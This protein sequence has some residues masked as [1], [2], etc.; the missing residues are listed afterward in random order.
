MNRL[1]AIAAAFALI[2][3]PAVA[4]A[5]DFV[6]KVKTSDLNLQ[7]EGGARTALNRIHSAAKDACT[8]KVVGSR[9]GRTDQSC[10]DQVSA[11]LVKRLGAPLV[12]AAFEARQT[13]G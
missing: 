1:T 12:Q 9:I 8:D 13:K 6:A 11:E 5:T 7:T 4:S 10:V 3:A 2:A